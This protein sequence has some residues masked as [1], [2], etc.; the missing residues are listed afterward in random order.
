MRMSNP[1]IPEPAIQLIEQETVAFFQ[2]I[3]PDIMNKMIPIYAQFFTHEE[4]KQLI[5]FNDTEIGKKTIRIRPL[6]RQQLLEISYQ[7]MDGAIPE[8][9]QRIT[10][11]LESEGFSV[12]K[13]F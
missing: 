10:R 11:R 5:A 1:G 3:A 8:L 12:K 7:Y 2:E 13:K 6:L 9:M 4:I